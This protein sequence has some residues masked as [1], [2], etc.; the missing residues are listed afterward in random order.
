MP[1]SRLTS[2]FQTTVPKDVRQALGAA[3]ADVLDWDVREGEVAVTVARPAFLSLRGT[4]ATG[5]GNAVRDV[6]LARKQRG[7]VQR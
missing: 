3:P 7:R 6:R 1:R 4:I 2:K 5:R